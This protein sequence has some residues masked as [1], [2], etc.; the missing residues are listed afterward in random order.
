M[1]LLAD[2]HVFLWYA[3]GSERIPPAVRTAL[4]DPQNDVYLSVASIW[5]TI[6]K[7]QLG[8]LPLPEHPATYLPQ[9]R[10]R[11]GFDSLPIDE[12]CMVHLASLPPHH[13]DPFDRVI[14]AQAIQHQLVVVS[15]DE[16]FRSYT[17]PLLE[18]A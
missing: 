15:V 11:H 4:Q 12:G 8:R 2:T 18:W 17:I 7:H 3:S 10:V 6:I 16:I 9:Q 14:L 1:R 5:E 13:R